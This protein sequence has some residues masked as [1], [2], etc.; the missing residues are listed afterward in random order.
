M[1]SWNNAI[2]AHSPAS[3]PPIFLPYLNGERAPIWDADARGVYFGINEGCNEE[4]LAYA[5]LEGVV[6]S[7]YHIYESMG[8]PKA[9][10]MKISGGAAV[11][12]ILNRL[13]SEMFNI[14]AEILAENDTS[15][16]GAAMIA[17]LGAGWY[18][19]VETLAKDVC[20]MKEIV[21]PTG[22][23]KE[24]LEKRYTIYKELYPAVKTQ[25]ERLKELGA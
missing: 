17:A 5:A 14:P 2:I 18:P 21:W 4:L 8:K 24:W 13:K 25:Y 19:D 22:Q 1:I 11:F 15:A 3:Q 9:E 10:A 20:K 6:F 7:L 23:Y 12:P 16:L